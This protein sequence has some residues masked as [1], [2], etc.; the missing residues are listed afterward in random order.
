LKGHF[1]LPPTLEPFGDPFCARP[2]NHPHVLRKE[3]ERLSDSSQGSEAADN[4]LEQALRSLTRS[5]IAGWTA[6]EI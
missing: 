6:T 1:P 3:N 5:R 2:A 4:Q